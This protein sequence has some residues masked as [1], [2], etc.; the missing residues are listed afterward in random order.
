MRFVRSNTLQPSLSHNRA[1]WI[2]S[3]NSIVHFAHSELLQISHNNGRWIVEYLRKLSKEYKVSHKS[4]ELILSSMVQEQVPRCAHRWRKLA[5]TWVDLL[6]SNAWKTFKKKTNVNHS[7]KLDVDRTCN[8]DLRGCK[9]NRRLKGM[10]NCTTQSMQGIWNHNMSIT[11]NH[12]IT[13][14]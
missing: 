8:E 1:S 9:F 7:T 10:H 6:A 13:L 3:S 11:W 12:D 2:I 5:V 14:Y 4:T